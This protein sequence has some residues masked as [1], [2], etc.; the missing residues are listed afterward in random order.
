MGVFDRVIRVIAAVLMGYLAYYNIVTGAWGVVL[1]I[2]SIVF[3]ITALVGIC[4]LYSLL[5]I[6]T[7][8][9]KHG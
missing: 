3:F 6:K 1:T 2:L 8:S 5:G 4:P 7:L 9:H